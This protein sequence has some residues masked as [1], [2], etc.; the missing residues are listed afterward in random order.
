MESEFQGYH[1]CRCWKA[2]RFYGAGTEETGRLYHSHHQEPSPGLFHRVTEK[3]CSFTVWPPQLCW[4]LIE[5][6]MNRA[7][8]ARTMHLLPQER[9][10][11]Y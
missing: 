4:V 5:E 2:A 8:R 6:E 9:R 7:R 11:F 1:A 3:R 10:G